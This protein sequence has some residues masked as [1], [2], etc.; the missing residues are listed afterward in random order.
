MSCLSESLTL[1]RTVYQPTAL[2]NE[3]GNCPKILH[4]PTLSA[5]DFSMLPCI[6]S[7]H[8][9]AHGRDLKAPLAMSIPIGS[10]N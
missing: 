8:T 3:F 2:F 5:K 10:A 1:S 9:T 4:R 7:E 6:F